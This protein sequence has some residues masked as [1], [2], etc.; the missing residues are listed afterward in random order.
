MERRCWTSRH[1]KK[2]RNWTSRHL[3]IHGLIAPRRYS[4][5]DVLRMT[6]SFEEKLVREDMALS[7]KEGCRMVFL[8]K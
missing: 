8:W 2:K 7:I 6:N 3:Y 4:Y 1:V 5:S